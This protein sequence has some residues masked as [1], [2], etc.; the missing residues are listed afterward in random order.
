MKTIVGILIVVCVL[1]SSVYAKEEQIDAKQFIQ[2]K[3]YGWGTYFCNSEH[4][5]MGCKLFISDNFCKL[6]N[7]YD[8]QEFRNYVWPIS[9]VKEIEYR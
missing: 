8:G 7:A 4:I 9:R 1:C 2:V 3:T 5:Y 6:Y